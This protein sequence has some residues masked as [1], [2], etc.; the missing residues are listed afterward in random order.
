MH[1]LRLYE[2]RGTLSE[3]WQSSSL[4]RIRMYTYIYICACAFGRR[5]ASVCL[6]FLFLY[7]Y[8]CYCSEWGKRERERERKEIRWWCL[9]YGIARIE[10]KE[11]S[12]ISIESEREKERTLPVFSFSSFLFYSLGPLSHLPT[13]CISNSRCLILRLRQLSSFVSR[14]WLWNYYLF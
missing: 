10:R 7:F 3:I 11:S 4:A 5:S 8:S 2:H 14:Q 1:I 9:F 13:V 12:K 6:S